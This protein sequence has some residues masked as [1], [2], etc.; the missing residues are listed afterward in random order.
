MI[1]IR[2]AKKRTSL[3]IVEHEKKVRNIMNNIL[4]QLTN[5]IQDD[6]NMNSFI[7]LHKENIK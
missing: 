4:K 1:N 5:I 7:T 2:T 6:E 3:Q